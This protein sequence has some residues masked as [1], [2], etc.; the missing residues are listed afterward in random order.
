MRS[1]NL[2]VIPHNMSNAL[3]MISF[4]CDTNHHVST[5]LSDGFYAEAEF[6]EKYKN[7]TKK[8]IKT[9]KKL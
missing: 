2:P 9:E 4:V 7:L 8:K 5:M 3:F 1:E 6:I